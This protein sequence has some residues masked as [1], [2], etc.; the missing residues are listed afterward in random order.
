MTNTNCRDFSAILL[1]SMIFSL[2]FIDEKRTVC[3]IP[4]FRYHFG[5]LDHVAENVR[6]ALDKRSQTRNELHGLAFTIIF[7]WNRNSCFF[8]LLILPKMSLILWR[9]SEKFKILEDVKNDS[10]NIRKSD[11]NRREHWN[12]ASS[13]YAQN[14][15]LYEFRG[16]SILG[17]VEN[18]KAQKIGIYI[19]QRNIFWIFWKLSFY[20]CIFCKVFN[21]YIYQESNKS[22]N[23]HCYAKMVKVLNFMFNCF[24]YF[25][26]TLL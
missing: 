24:N 1:A 7:N 19:E 4:Y 25:L 23:Y 9:F 15:V 16:N 17:N 10:L 5:N 12:C 26:L 8:L 14:C 22:I 11:K 3:V 6:H 2:I 21:S 18:L 13:T 20:K